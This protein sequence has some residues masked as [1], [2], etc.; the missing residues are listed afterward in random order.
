M[1]IKIGD[2]II[3][4]GLL[5]ISFFMALYFSSF[6]S[7]NTGQYIRIEQKSKLVGEYPLNTDK[8]IVLEDDGKYNKV[9]IKN[10]KAYMEEANC[11]DQICVH[12]KK[13]NVGGETIVCLPN[14][15][16]VEVI[17]EYDNDSIDKVN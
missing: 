10:G 3:S 5:V 13:I 11:R 12:M 14:R 8:E 17:D 2:I 1:K 4:L 6:H 15:V 9:I 16:F 7:K